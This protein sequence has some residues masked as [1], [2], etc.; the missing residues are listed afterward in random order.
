MKNYTNIS[1][2][3]EAIDSL[4]REVIREKREALES[5]VWARYNQIQ[6]LLNGGRDILTLSTG[7]NFRRLYEQRRILWEK[8]YEMLRVIE[9][10]S[11]EF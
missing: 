3:N 1:Y 9:M 10:I 11:K 7:D 8:S 4:V 5:R 6:K 2:V